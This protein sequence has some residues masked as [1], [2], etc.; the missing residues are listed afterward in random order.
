MDLKESL[1]YLQ[2]E[3]I[4]EMA[5]DVQREYEVDVQYLEYLKESLHWKMPNNVFQL[6]VELVE[7]Q[8]EV[9]NKVDDVLDILLVELEERRN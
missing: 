8:R 9:I 7:L 5:D 4:E 1:Q 2:D 6:N 3:T